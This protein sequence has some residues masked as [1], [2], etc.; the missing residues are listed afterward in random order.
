MATGFLQCRDKTLCGV[1][2]GLAEIPVDGP[3]HVPIGL[4]AGDNITRCSSKV[5]KIKL[6]L[7]ITSDRGTFLSAAVEAQHHAHSVGVF[8]WAW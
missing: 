1:R 6:I 7:A 3:I 4:L 5:G 2:G 8:A